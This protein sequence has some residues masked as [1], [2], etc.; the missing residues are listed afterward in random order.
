LPAVISAIKKYSSHFS[1]FIKG[2]TPAQYQPL[3]EAG[4]R[5]YKTLPDLA[6]LLP[7]VRGVIHGGGI[8]LAQQAL[9]AGVP[10]LLIPTDLEK[11]LAAAV[12]A[13][14]AGSL[15]V[16]PDAGQ[17]AFDTAVQTLCTASPERALAAGRFYQGQLPSLSG[18]DALVTLLQRALS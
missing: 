18:E 13:K 7:T 15:V 3:S 4:V 8:G 11:T 1:A 5:I 10:Q 16:H 9:L 12:L 6:T 14:T 17:Q 2:G